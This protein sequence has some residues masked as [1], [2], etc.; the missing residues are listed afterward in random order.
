[1]ANIDFRMLIPFLRVVMTVV[2]TSSFSLDLF[3]ECDWLLVLWQKWLK[4]CS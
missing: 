1:M 4:I 3:A 2:I